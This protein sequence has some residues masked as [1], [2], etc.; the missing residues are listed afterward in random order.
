MQRH[1]RKC[2][3]LLLIGV[4]MGAAM[5]ARAATLSFAPSAQVVDLGAVVSV[6]VYAT[7][8]DQQRVGAYAFLIEFDPLLVAV[9]S[10][11][12][13]PSLGNPF[14][15]FTDV[16]TG[17]GQVNVSEVS[18]LTDLSGLQSGDGELLLVTLRFQTL[19]EGT[20]PLRFVDNILGA[21]GIFLGDEA[22]APLT[23]T[24]PSAGSITVV[25]GPPPPPPPPPPTSVPE[26]SLPLLL[27]AALAASAL[28]RRYAAT[29][30]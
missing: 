9:L 28:A 7:D 3:I 27:V 14:D 22:G 13:G 6:D 19:A 10:A 16:V 12:F 30:S 26:P 11:D 8:L 29:R 2:A 5:A 23:L 24:P 20:T 15:N 21:P 17:S 1:L 18:L 4:A 25:V